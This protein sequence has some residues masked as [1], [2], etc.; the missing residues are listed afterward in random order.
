MQKRRHNHAIPEPI[1]YGA[2]GPVPSPI[3]ILRALGEVIYFAEMPDGI[4][5]IGHT[6]NLAVR[7]HGWTHR[8]ARI[9]A[10]RFGSLED[11]Q[12]IHA[13]LADSRAFGREWYHPTDEVMAEVESARADMLALAG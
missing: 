9:L 11:E 2:S 10:F 6:K 4:I 8:G 3:A 7:R 1:D 5:K 12:L 13:G